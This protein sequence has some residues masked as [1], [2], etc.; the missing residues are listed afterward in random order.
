MVNV[1]IGIVEKEGKILL[2]QRERGDFFGLWGIPGGKVEECEHIDEAVEREMLEEI[3]IK[4]NFKELLGISTEIMH[5]KN[6]TSI[7]YVCSLTYEEDIRIENAEFKYKWFSME[8]LLNSN[9]IIE[10]DK[11]FIDKF[12]INR[13]ERYLKLDC[14][15][16]NNS[17]YY[18]K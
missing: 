16:D 3:G 17:N 4:L 2:I 9:E 14:Y 13:L 18:W 7:I 5:N 11:I 8:E 15:K 1:V 12:Y 6:S 10:S